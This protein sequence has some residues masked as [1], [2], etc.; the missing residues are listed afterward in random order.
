MSQGCVLGELAGQAIRLPVGTRPPGD[1]AELW[2]QEAGVAMDSDLACG[3]RGGSFVPLIHYSS[4]LSTAPSFRAVAPLAPASLT[5]SRRD[6]SGPAESGA[7]LRKLRAQSSGSNS[8]GCQTQK[9]TWCKEGG[10]PSFICS[11][12]GVKSLLGE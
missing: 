2:A 1:V 10:L 8:G 9:G 6:T 4:R 11:V 7:E 12:P 3:R 5:P